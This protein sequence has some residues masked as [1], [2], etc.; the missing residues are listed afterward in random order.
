M[1]RV[2][3]NIVLIA[4]VGVL[5]IGGVF[6]YN[7]LNPDEPI[8]DSSDATDQGDT[9]ES[10]GTSSDSEETQSKELST[11]ETELEEITTDDSSTSETESEDTTTD[12]SSTPDMEPEDTPEDDTSPEPFSPPIHSSL[13]SIPGDDKLKE[14]L[15]IPEGADFAVYEFSYVDILEWYTEELENLTLVDEGT[16]TDPMEGMTFTWVKY[17]PQDDGLILFTINNPEMLGPVLGIIQGK[18]NILTDYT[19]SLPFMEGDMSVEGEQGSIESMFPSYLP[20]PEDP[21][22]FN[23][24]PIA[25]EDIE[26]IWP[27]GELGPDDGHIFPT[28]NGYLMWK[29]PEAYPPSI[30]VVAPSDGYIIELTYHKLEWP[31]ESGRTGIYNDYEIRIA[32][33]K[34]QIIRLG[35]VSE[36]SED[37][38]SRI[39]EVSEGDNHLELV[40]SEG[41]LLGYTGGRPRAQYT[42]NWRIH[43]LSISSYIHPE[44]YG[45][46]STEAHFLEYCTPE[47]YEQLRPLMT[48]NVEPIIGV[49]DYDILG[50]LSGNWFHE[51][52][53]T[54]EP[55]VEWDKQLSFCYD[56]HDPNKALLSVGGTLDIPVGVYLVENETPKFSQVDTNCGAIYYQLE[57][58]P[59]CDQYSHM[60]KITV[61]VELLDS[62]T[63]KIEA[64]SGWIPDP[65]FSENAQIYT[66]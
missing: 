7:I 5:I 38:L 42:M 50:T 64:F 58:D 17:H 44:K 27:F 14:D 54:D 62:E 48:R 26:E 11:S 21:I 12:D 19:P 53:E 16:Q 49:Y 34:T 22:Q 10:T 46:T 31:S 63:L 65:V 52:I 9:T 55:I 29:N 4:I 66:R 30:E 39:G 3:K 32:T 18:W 15:Q 20:L 45:L 60:P 51:D 43:A 56:R 33:A 57:G 6:A 1:S 37:L 36:L 35:H 24:P 41:E 61:L 28:Q 47:L 59:E 23:T 25:I 13:Q 8:Q 2:N 40:V